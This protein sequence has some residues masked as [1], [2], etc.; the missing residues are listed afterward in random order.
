MILH[1]MMPHELMFP[2]E[3]GFSHFETLNVQ[4]VPVLAEQLDEGYRIVRI[5]STNPYD[6][7]RPGLAPGNVV[8]HAGF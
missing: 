7:L 8:R 2:E 6:F 1:T 5:L 3:A 4:G